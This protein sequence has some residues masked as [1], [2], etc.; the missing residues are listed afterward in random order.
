MPSSSG[1]RRGLNASLASGNRRPSAA[2]S[3]TRISNA[4]LGGDGDLNLNTS[5]D[6]DDDLLNGLGGGEQARSAIRQYTDSPSRARICAGC[7]GC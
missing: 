2:R 1:Y 4:P 5:L 6:V 3:G 7:S